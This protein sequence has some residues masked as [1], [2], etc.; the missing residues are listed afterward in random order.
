MSNALPHAMT[1]GRQ[2]RR[3]FL[4]AT[5]GVIAAGAIPAW[6]GDLAY[7]SEKAPTSPNDRPLVGAIGTGGQ[8]TGIMNASARFGDVVAVCDVDANHAR[9][10]KEG[11]E[12]MRP[13]ATV[14]MYEDYRKLLDR[15]D[16]TAVTVGTPDHWHTR[17]VIDAMKAGKDV[18]CEKPLTLTIA[19]GQQII[20]TAESTKR[21]LQ[22]GTQ[23][24]SHDPHL[25]LR[26]IATI[27]SGQLG[28][29]KKV[30]VSLP[31]S[32]GVGG[33]FET[34]PVPEN[35]NWDLWLGQAPQVDYCP[36]RCHFTFRWW[37]EYSGGILTDWGAH[38]MDIAQWGL[39]TERS[40]PVSIDGTKTVMPKVAGGYNTPKEPIVSCTY[41]DGAVVE[42]VTGDEGVL[43][44]GEKGRLYVNRGRVT[45]KPIENQDNDKSLQDL[46]NE[47]MA[48]LYGP[49]KPGNHMGDFF[50]SIRS[51]ELPISDMYSQ[52]RSVSA[53]HLANIS[54][55]LGRKLAW[56]PAAEKFSG[57]EEANKMI[58]R[59]QRAPYQ[60]D[61]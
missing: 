32:T 15:N 59:A 48:K 58:S 6:L 38:H 7:A 22:V 4:Q 12:K 31:L 44:E 20:K 24:R 55:R 40:G 56:D 11:I 5:T 10:A 35:L 2:T 30:T 1:N 53:C 14:A 33:P 61:A 54:V 19:E 39:G 42:I 45:G 46:T 36:E 60:I 9:R 16:I 57:D 52:H 8:G 51:R 50:E 17:I 41:A 37:Y 29:V 34:K 21:I 27:R 13:G 47:W 25:F 23:Q 18:Y 26:A 49:R 3:H 43:F 28:K